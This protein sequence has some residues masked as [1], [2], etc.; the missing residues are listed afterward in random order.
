[1]NTFFNLNCTINY[2]WDFAST[3]GFGNPSSFTTN[4]TYTSPV[5]YSALHTTLLSQ[6]TD[7]L[8]TIAY[9]SANLP[10]TEAGLTGSPPVSGT[11]YSWPTALNTV[12]TNGTFPFNSLA[13]L[14]VI[15]NTGATWSATTD[16]SSTSG[17]VSL[18][19]AIAHEF[20]EA[21]GRDTSL[22]NS[23]IG[24]L[25]LFV[26]KSNNVRSWLKTDTRY[27][28]YHNGSSNDTTSDAP[29]GGSGIQGNYNSSTGDWGGWGGSYVSP[30][31]EQN[32][33]Y[34]NGNFGLMLPGDVRQMALLGFPL[35]TYGAWYAG[36]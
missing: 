8:K 9:S 33:T 26:F 32:L 18:Y 31:N 24:P 21:L 7:A 10:T 25:D 4:L 36:V 6:P 19:G 23:N 29:N 15:I 22:A 27:M 3:A 16:G 14:G 28:S 11:V 13:P 35:T 30:F 1:M 5:T 12:Y 34:A 17:H 20:T 2:Q